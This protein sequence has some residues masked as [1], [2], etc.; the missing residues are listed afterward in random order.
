MNIHII[1]RSIYLTRHGESVFNLCGRI[2][3]DSELSDRGTEY[4]KALA[5]Y[6]TEQNIPRLR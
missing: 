5:K 3:G 6:I 2:G 4:A 1:P